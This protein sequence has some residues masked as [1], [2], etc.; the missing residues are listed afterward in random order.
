MKVSMRR[1]SF[2]V[3]MALAGV[4]MQAVV[5]R[6]QTGASK[7]PTGID[8]S[9]LIDL[10]YDFDE[11]AIYWPNAKPFEWQKE[12]WGQ[13]A[14]GYWYAAA[15]YSA[16]EHGGTH[17]DSPIH[18]AEGKETLDQIPVSKL[19]GPAVVIDVSKACASN[20]DYRVTADDI[21][22][23]EKAN[24]RIVEGGIVLVRTGWG[25][26]WPDRK[27]YLGSDVAGDT[28]HLHFPGFSREAAELL[29]SRKVRG[30]GLDT[31]SL[32]YGPSKDFIV[33]RVL[34]GA[35]IYGLENVANLEKVPTT[36]ATLIALPMK[37]KGGSGGPVRIVA[38]VP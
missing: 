26:F 15:R 23:W 1:F 6:A 28:A 13:S 32:D 18:F 2:G 35:G 34:N 17:I 38:L 33:H 7:A 25:K 19:V 29:V 24:G 20:P 5:V 36:G 10:T 16:S 11:Q 8:A 3:A 31:A 21:T 12:S 14:G 4:L 30:V 37:I 27:R 9:K 22:A